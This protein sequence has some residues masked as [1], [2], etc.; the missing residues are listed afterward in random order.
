M[1][2]SGL[3]KYFKPIYNNEKPIKLSQQDMNLGAKSFWCSSFI[4]SKNILIKGE[5]NFTVLKERKA[6]I[7]LTDPRTGEIKGII[8]YNE[9]FIEII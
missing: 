6:L 8:F 9:D 3:E 5:Y 2:P 4:K 7:I 1:N